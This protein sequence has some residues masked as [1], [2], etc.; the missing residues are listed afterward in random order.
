MDLSSINPSAHADQ[1]DFPIGQGKFKNLPTVAKG[2]SVTAAARKLNRGLEVAEGIT[3]AVP[4]PEAMAIAGMVVNPTDV[5]LDIERR[6]YSL[7]RTPSGYMLVSL[8][9]RVWTAAVS[10]DGANGRARLDTRLGGGTIWPLP[11]ERPEP[12]L[13]YRTRSLDRM[14]DAAR[15]TAK[16]IASADMRIRLREHPLGVWNPVYIA[17]GRI[18]IVD[19]PDGDPLEELGFAHVIE[20]STRISHAQEGIGLPRDVA[21]EFAGDTLNLV[22]RVRAGIAGRLVVQPDSADVH[23]AVKLAT[24]PAHI[25]I[26]VLDPDGNVST[27]PFR[28]VIDEFVQSIHEEPRPWVP[29]AQGGVR[30][31]RLVRDL[32]EHDRLEHEHGLDVVGRDEFHEVTTPLNVIAG[33]LLRAAS[34]PHSYPVVRKA[35]LED[36]KGKNL[37][38]KRYAQ[39]VG[40]LMLAI[41][42]EVPQRQKNAVAALT[43]GDF[44]P[45]MLRTTDW[46]VRADLTVREVLAEALAHIEANPGTVSPAAEELVAR[47]VGAV[48][49]LG[50]VFS[51]QGSAVKDVAWLRGSVA[52]IAQGLATCPGGLQILCE[53]AEKA[54]DDDLPWPILY[55]VDGEPVLGDDGR[56]E[57]LHPEEG[58]NVKVRMLAKRGERPDDDEEQGEDDR[59]LSPHDRYIRTQ[60][61]IAKVGKGL[62]TAVMEELAKLV[63]ETGTPLIDSKEFDREILGELPDLLAEVRDIILINLEPEYEEPEYDAGDEYDADATGLTAFDGDIDAEES[64]D[65]E[66]AA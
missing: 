49:T 44:E 14:R 36:T 55:D 22:R 31:E 66:P 34:H 21:V 10:C 51:D 17:P 60:R 13:V 59:E 62:Y 45:P 8:E 20:G 54:E 19:S 5:R 57:R 30:G 52:R 53:A 37:T 39:T 32:V 40:S 6:R 24:L 27:A 16:R 9:T 65:L 50:L 3:V 63:D 33:R 1:T 56:P 2:V 15:D 61:H 46:K 47:S 23:H 4:E 64:D 12:S 11:G 58:A 7:H 18:D 26:G 25:I 38:R 35:I 48:A 43:G 28:E 29:I 41:Y 42:G